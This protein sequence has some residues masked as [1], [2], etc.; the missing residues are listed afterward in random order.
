VAIDLTGGMEASA[1]YFLA[2]R[3]EDPEFRESASFWVSDDQGAIGLPRVGIEA[4][5]GNAWDRRGL[6]VNLGFPDGRSVIVREAGEGRSP[7]DDDGICRTFAAGG[8]VFRCI[9]PFKT[10]TMSFDGPALDTTAAALATG[11]M[12]GPRVPLRFEVELTCAAPPWRSG[13][14]TEAAR[15]LFDEGFAGAFISPRYEQLCTAKGTVELGSDSWTFTGTALRIHR[16]GMRDTGGFWGHCWPSALFPSGRGFG[17]LSFPERPGEPTFNEAFIFDGERLIPATLVDPPW[18]R[19]T[20]PNGE[21]VAVTLR[22]EGGD[23]IRIEG[24]TILSAFMDGRANP[25]FPMVLQQAGVRYTWD[26]EVSY[27]MLERSTPPDQ[28]GT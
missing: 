18:L 13:T 19:G 15:K 17:G 3:P 6:Q 9:E 4:V 8:L 27:G 26:G 22:T 21:D 25:E 16:Q 23:E 28:I 7:V 5:A 10:L 24:E 12:S 20:E 14:L 2:E 1:D 11:D